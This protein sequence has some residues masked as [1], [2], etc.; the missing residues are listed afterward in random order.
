MAIFANGENL[1]IEGLQYM[2]SN[3]YD[4]AIRSFTNAIKKGDYE[5]IVL[6][7]DAKWEYGGKG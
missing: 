6:L 7:A 5:S 2:A 4:R 3:A 1:R